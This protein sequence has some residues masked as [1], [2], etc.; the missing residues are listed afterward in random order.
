MLDM[1]GLHDGGTVDVSAHGGGRR[2]R[3]ALTMDELWTDLGPVFQDVFG[4]R[5]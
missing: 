3:E 2:G 1:T 5:R 4:V